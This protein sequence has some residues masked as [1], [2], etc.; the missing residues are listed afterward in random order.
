MHLLILILTLIPHLTQMLLE[1]GAIPTKTSSNIPTDAP[2][3]T[4]KLR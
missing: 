2:P 1:A 3:S 4:G